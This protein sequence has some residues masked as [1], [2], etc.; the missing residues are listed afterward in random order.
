VNKFDTKA[1]LWC[2]ASRW[3]ILEILFL[4]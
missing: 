3:S 2:G 4:S 1:Q